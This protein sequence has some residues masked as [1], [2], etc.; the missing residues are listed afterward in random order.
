MGR[1]KLPPLMWHRKLAAPNWATRICHGVLVGGRLNSAAEVKGGGTVL[2]PS[3]PGGRHGKKSPWK[4]IGE[5]RLRKEVKKGGSV[6][7]AQFRKRMDSATLKKN[8]QERRKLNQ[9]FKTENSYP[10]RRRISDF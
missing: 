7:T 4:F 3:P 8:L 10:T 6:L 1:R 2:H 9:R 5:R